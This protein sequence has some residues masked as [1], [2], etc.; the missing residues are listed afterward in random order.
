MID[1]I[2]FTGVHCHVVKL[3]PKTNV[4]MMEVIKERATFYGSKMFALFSKC[5][6]FILQ[7]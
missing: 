6:D 3:N 2:S 1:S 5:A 4:N 7:K